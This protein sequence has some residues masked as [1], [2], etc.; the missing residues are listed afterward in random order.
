[1][2][3]KKGHQGPI[4]Y[5]PGGVGGSRFLSGLVKLLSPDELAIVVNTADD[6]DFYGLHISPDL[7]TTLYKL[8]GLVSQEGWGIQ[9][10]T[11][12]CLE[13]LG[14]LGQES[15][16]RLGDKDLAV[17]ILRT[18]LL[19]QGVPLSA[20]TERL[21]LLFGVP[22]R[23]L[24]MSD[25]RIETWI[26]TKEHGWVHFQ[27]Y[28]VKYQSTPTVIGFCY[29]GLES[30]R[31]TPA[32]LKALKEA[33]VVIIGPSNPI[34]SI[35]PILK[36]PGIMDTLTHTAKPIV[37]ISPLI[38]GRPLKGPLDKLLEALGQKPSNLAVAWRYRP[39]LKGLVIHGADL[40]DAPDLQSEG[41]EVLVTN[42]LMSTD[43]DAYGL[44]KE[45][46]AFAKSTFG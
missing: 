19:G 1:M 35:E 23:I 28:L 3:R 31:A 33:S 11:F 15:W 45:T 6:R 8:A 39:F 21:A 32:V 38:G 4:V 9:G 2:T 14:R 20:T 36:L 7:D 46:L 10:D 41:I 42:T 5:L 40:T 25:E 26:E 29:R 24:P 30:A 17:H 44:A 16:F 43:E 27:E 34:T 12:F 37:A 18:Q 13:Q 22:W